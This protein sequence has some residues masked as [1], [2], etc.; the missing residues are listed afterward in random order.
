[1]N[2]RDRARFDTL[3]E[4]VIEALPAGLRALLDEVALILDDEPGPEILAE[5]GDEAADLL[6]LHTGTPFTEQGIEYAGPP[7]T[8]HLFREAIVDQ[9]CDEW[10]GYPDGWRGAESDDAVREEIRVTLLHEIGHQFGLDEDDL[11]RLG[12]E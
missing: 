8:I 4:Q 5:M 6:G 7:P 10:G 3:A 11:G 12:Y 9:A 2:R 1:M